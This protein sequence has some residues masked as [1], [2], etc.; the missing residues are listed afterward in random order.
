MAGRARRFREQKWLLDIV[1]STLGHDSGQGPVEA[2]VQKFAPLEI[3][4]P[5]SEDN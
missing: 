4:A 1:I 3:G 2:P 5:K